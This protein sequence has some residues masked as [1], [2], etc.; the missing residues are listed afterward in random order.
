MR[1]LDR[2]RLMNATDYAREMSRFWGVETLVAMRMGLD[3]TSYNR[4]LI[5]YR[6]AEKA[7]AIC[8]E[9]N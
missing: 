8:R 4:A 3:E 7:G 1:V 2:A 9:D 6:W 5:A